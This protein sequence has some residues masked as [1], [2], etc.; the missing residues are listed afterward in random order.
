MEKNDYFVQ[1]FWTWITNS[2]VR[3][4]K[5]ICPSH[6][7]LINGYFTNITTALPTRARYSEKMH[8][9]ESALTPCN[10]YLCMLPGQ[11]TQEANPTLWTL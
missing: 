7:Y 11:Q 9:P 2:Y 3:L 6:V 10:K 1:F 8:V 5:S 4:D